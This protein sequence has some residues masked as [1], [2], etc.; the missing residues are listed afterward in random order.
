MMPLHGTNCGAAS[1]DLVAIV[2]V[3]R[4][5]LTGPLVAVTATDSQMVARCSR[6]IG[7]AARSEISR[8]GSSAVGCAV[9]E[10][11]RHSELVGVRFP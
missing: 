2:T 5:Q 3:E 10:P 7:S 11:Q 6:V 8:N 4:D 1:D 9:H